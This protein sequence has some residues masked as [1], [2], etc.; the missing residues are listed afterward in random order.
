ME[1]KLE[2]Q[3]ELRYRKK[4][5]LAEYLKFTAEQEKSLAD[6]NL[7]KVISAIGRKQSVVEEINSLDTEMV[8][9]PEDVGLVEADRELASMLA[10][11]LKLEEKN[12]N[13][14]KVRR[15]EIAGRL[16]ELRKKK[17]GCEA[18]APPLKGEGF[19][20]NKNIK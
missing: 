15:N 19:F 3:S 9:V 2:F 13:M 8:R 10:G 5:L 7:D 20:L 16:A 17:T 6:D 14:I 12:I 11:A 18:Y 1:K 4:C